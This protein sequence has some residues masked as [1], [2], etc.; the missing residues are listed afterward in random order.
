MRRARAT[1]CITPMKDGRYKHRGILRVGVN[2]NGKPKSKIFYGNTKKEVENKINSYLNQDL[3]EQKETLTFNDALDLLYKQSEKEKVKQKTLSII[4]TTSNILRKR[5][6]EIC[7]EN[8]FLNEVENQFSIWEEE[9]SFSQIQKLRNYGKK[10]YKLICNKYDLNYRNPFDLKLKAPNEAPKLNYFTEEEIYLINKEMT[11][12]YIDIPLFL[13]ETGMRINEAL[14]LQFKDI[15][16]DNN[17]IKV[18]KTLS[19]TKQKNG[20]YQISVTTPKTKLSYRMVPMTKMV[21]DI[22][23]VKDQGFAKNDDLVF[24][25]GN[26]TYLSARNVLRAFDSAIKK[27]NVEKI[28]VDFIQFG[29]QQLFVYLGNFLLMGEAVK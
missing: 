27:A 8:I 7:I 14:A 12:V 29:I 19:E 18:D 22:L 25:S 10:A 4:E 13:Y 16:Y 20:K 3:P 21:R 26:N 17:V 9:Y 2:K 6:G 15:D 1:G 23:L 24:P 11:G 28:I 5:W